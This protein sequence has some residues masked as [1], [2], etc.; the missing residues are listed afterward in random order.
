MEQ[1]GWKKHS[2]GCHKKSQK[3]TEEHVY[4]VV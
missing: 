2:W 1:A 4:D 3:A